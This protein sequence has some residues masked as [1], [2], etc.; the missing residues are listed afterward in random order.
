M[1]PEDVPIW[2]DVD[3]GQN[4]SLPTAVNATG[5]QVYS[6]SSPND[7]TKLRQ[8]YTDLSNQGTIL[9]VVDQPAQLSVLWLLRWLKRCE[10]RSHTHL[11]WRCAELSTCIQGMR[12][13]T[14]VMR[15]L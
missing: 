4:R 9:V 5:Q 7:E 6:H 15:S 8:I 11:V 14:S 10:L 3:A 12:R 13:R 1:K 2:L